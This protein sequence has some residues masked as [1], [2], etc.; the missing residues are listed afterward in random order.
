[1][2]L[3]ARQHRGRQ[4]DILAGQG[5]R[6][7]ERQAD[8]AH[9]G[10]RNLQQ[11]AAVRVQLR[12]RRSTDVLPHAVCADIRVRVE[13]GAAEMKQAIEAAARGPA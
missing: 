1:V 11:V 3:D 9:R 4:H 5:G 13:R 7:A 8:A 10:H 2:P 6:L 12:P